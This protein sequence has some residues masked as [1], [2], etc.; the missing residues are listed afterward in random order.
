MQCNEW[1]LKL[2]LTLIKPAV[3][4]MLRT[5]GKFLISVKYSMIL[6]ELQLILLG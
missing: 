4:G 1:F 2:N 6:R 5:T 3:N